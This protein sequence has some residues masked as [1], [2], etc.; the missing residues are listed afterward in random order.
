MTLSF[1][2]AGSVEEAIAP[3]FRDIM[4]VLNVYLSS[5]SDSD[6]TSLKVEAI[7]MILKFMFCCY[8]YYFV[9][10]EC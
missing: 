6:S 10:N 1:I 3:Y 4:N 8:S 9:M 2:L 7:G 5:P